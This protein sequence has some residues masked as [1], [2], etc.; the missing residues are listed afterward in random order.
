MSIGKSLTASK[1]YSTELKILRIA[2]PTM[3]LQKVIL[4]IIPSSMELI[5][6]NAFSDCHSLNEVHWSL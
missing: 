4:I 3:E 1:S 6:L 2:I 5:G